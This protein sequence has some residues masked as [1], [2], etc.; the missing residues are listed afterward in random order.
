[1]VRLGAAWL[2]G[3]LAAVGVFALGLAAF[4][5]LLFAGPVPTRP[6]GGPAPLIGVGLP[7][8][9]A[10]VAAVLVARHY[11]RKG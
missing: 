8:A 1:M 10:V 7:I 2:F 9:G 6:S 3:V 4:P 11:W 5:E